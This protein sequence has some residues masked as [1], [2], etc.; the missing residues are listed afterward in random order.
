MTCEL[1]S[2]Q[3]MAPEVLQLAAKHEGKRLARYGQ[4]ADIFSL[5]VVF[6]ELLHH[7]RPTWLR[8]APSRHT[9]P[10]MHYPAL[11]SALPAS[12][13]CRRALSTLGL[14]PHRP[15]HEGCEGVKEL[16][17]AVAA[18]AASLPVQPGCA[19][20]APPGFCDLMGLCL[21]RQHAS[22]PSAVEVVRRLL[23]CRKVLC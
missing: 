12:M 23:A 5:G 19:A 20:E 10:T 22:R 15:R 11:Y 14:C 13:N 16:R 8:P 7:A 18:G 21:Q 3:W 4:P 1:G 6:W 2:Y 17:A 9:H